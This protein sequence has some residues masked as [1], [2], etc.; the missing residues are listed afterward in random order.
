MQVNKL[1]HEISLAFK[2]KQIKERAKQ[3]NSSFIWIR[4]YVARVSGTQERGYKCPIQLEVSPKFIGNGRLGAGIIYIKK[5][6][7]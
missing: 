6:K 2:H 1:E 4:N 7:K 3:I 5:Y